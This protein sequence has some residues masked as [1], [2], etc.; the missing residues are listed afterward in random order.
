[1][2]LKNVML[3]NVQKIIII[4]KLMIIQTVINV[5]THVLILGKDIILLHMEHV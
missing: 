2:E 1:M 4:L 5:L 3:I